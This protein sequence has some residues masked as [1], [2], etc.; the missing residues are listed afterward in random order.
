[1]ARTRH[2]SASGDAAGAVARD[3]EDMSDAEST[4]QIKR[5]VQL[6]EEVARLAGEI[7][8]TEDRVA[9]VRRRL[10]TDDEARAAEHLRAAEDAERFAVHEREQQRRWQQ[11]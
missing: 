9:S 7:A 1:V 8:E 3:A 4:D 11:P 5:A 2:P 10:A 6:R